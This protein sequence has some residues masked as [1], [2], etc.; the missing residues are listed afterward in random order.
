M[1]DVSSGGPVRRLSLAR[2]GHALLAQFGTEEL[3]TQACATL[4]SWS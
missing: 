4:A 2:S 1:P 3:E